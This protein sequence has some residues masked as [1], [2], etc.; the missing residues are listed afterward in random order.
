MKNIT[1][2]DGEWRIMKLLWEKEPRTN[3][4]FVRELEND[5]GWTKATIFVMLKRLIAKGAVRMDE[6]APVHEYYASVSRDDVTPE[7]TDSFLTRVYD[8]SVA[9]MLSHMA[10][11]NA[12]TPE[13]IEELRRILDEA[14]KKGEKKA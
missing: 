4:E 10:E 5:T 3:G 11:R 6:D 13:E 14:E 1:L 9:L 2:S 8:G 12:L 7:E